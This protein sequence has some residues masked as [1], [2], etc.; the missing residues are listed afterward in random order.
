[1][2]GVQSITVRLTS[3]ISYRMVKTTAPENE[4]YRL[5]APPASDL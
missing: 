5:V 4:H 2:T 1:M 3:F